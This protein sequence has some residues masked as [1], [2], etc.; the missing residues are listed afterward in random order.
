MSSCPAVAVQHGH[1]RGEQHHVQ[2]RAV[3][4]R[5]A[6]RT[7]VAS[8]GGS[9]MISPRAGE[10]RRGRTREIGRQLERPERAAEPLA[11]EREQRLEPLA[12]R[13]GSRCHAAKSAYWIGSGAKVG[14][15]PARLGVVRRAQLAKQHA[16]RPAV[17]R[18][19][20][21]L[22]HEH[23]LARR[24]AR[25]SVTRE[26]AA[27]AP[28]RTACARLLEHDALRSRARARR[29]GASAT[30]TTFIATGAGGSMTCTGAV[31]L[32]GRERRAQAL[33]PRDDASNARRSASTSSGPASRRAIG[34]LY[35]VS[36]GVARS[37]SQSSS[38]ANDV[39]SAPPRGTAGDR[40]VVRCASSP[41][42]W[43]SSSIS[44]SKPPAARVVSVMRSPLPVS[45]APGRRAAARAPP[46]SCVAPVRRASR[47]A[48]RAPRPARDDRLREA[49]PRSARRRSR[50][51]SARRGRA[52]DA[53]VTTRV[54]SSEWPPSA[55][56]S[57]VTPTSRVRA[58][59]APDAASTRST[60]R[61][62]RH[63]RVVRARATPA[64]VARGDRP[65]RS[66]TAAT[67][68][69]ATSA[70]GTM[71]SGSARRSARSAA[72]SGVAVPRAR[73]NSRRAARR[74]P[75]LVQHRQRAAH[76]VDR[77]DE[78]LD[79]AELDAEA[80]QLHLEVEPAEVLDRA[81]GA[82]ARQVARAIHPRV[83][84]L[85]RPARTG[86]ARTARP[87]A[88]AGCGSRAPPARR[89]CTARRARRS[90]Q[91]APRASST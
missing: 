58:P 46:A 37:S 43:A 45:S 44:S 59:R 75:V 18:D 68:R 5:R 91:L 36:P 40:R 82:P 80:A 83:A 56:K 27:R 42:R 33:V 19:V 47:C 60:A 66:A 61:A 84:R 11:P 4:H 86:R 15:A 54:A 81:V 74:A 48:R 57:L 89:R 41:S 23:V 34:M 71:I 14:A 32:A 25:T 87:S 51:A 55:K 3:L 78:L 2:R 88:P 20:M 72:T 67:R 24:R 38:C 79:L 77:R 26:A 64:R 12:V 17:R 39:G 52:R 22:E 30:S 65:S 90:A 16:V 50:A 6:R 13:C 35:A 70:D 85:V 76:A 1:V 7:R 8:A 62:R 73:R 29:R 53:C 28:G 21:R 49:R 9:S 69:A 31:R 63:R 10:A